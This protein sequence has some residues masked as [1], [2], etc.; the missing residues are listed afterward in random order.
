VGSR[1]TGQLLEAD[2]Q[3]MDADG[4]TWWHLITGEFVREDFVSEEGNCASLETIVEFS[5][6][7]PQTPSVTPSATIPINAACM[8]TT[9][10]GV[11]LRGG[12]SVNFERVGSAAADTSFQADTQFTGTDGLT[13]WRLANAEQDTGSW[14]REDFVSEEGNCDALPAEES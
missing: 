4:F 13:W 7:T 2:G 5:T 8:I 9:L 10:S 12:P 11:N 3:A 6:H 1:A 14:V